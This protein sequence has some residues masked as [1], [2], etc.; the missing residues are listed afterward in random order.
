MTRQVPMMPII[1]LVLVIGFG[2]IVNLTAYQYST[3]YAGP[4][5]A[6]FTLGFVSTLMRYRGFKWLAFGLNKPQRWLRL[7]GQAALVLVGTVAVG[8][9][10]SKLVGLYLMSP[11]IT[12]SRFE[13]LQG[14]LIL[15][16]SWV[17]IGWVVG[18]FAEEMIFRGFLLNRCESMLSNLRFSTVLAIVFQAIIF[19][20]VHFYNRGLPA[21]ITI[22][23]VGLAMGTFYIKFGRSLWPLILAHGTIDTLSFLE[24]YLGA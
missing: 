19:A 17:V 9:I 18:G 24:D 6:V 14:N 5:T 23:A 15:F 20:A 3:N 4:V 2:T 10:V 1:D 16:L 12:Q 8:A 22:G 11:E 7:L 21:A 13:G